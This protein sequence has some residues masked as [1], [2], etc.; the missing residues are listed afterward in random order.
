[1]IVD[2]TDIRVMKYAF[3]DLRVWEKAVDLYVECHQIAITS[4]L[5]KNFSLA[6][7]IRRSALSIP[8][9]IAEGREGGSKRV[10]LRHVNIAVGSAAEL[11]T[12]L[13]C[14]HRLNYLSDDEL[15]KLKYTLDG[16][17]VPLY[18][19]RGHLVKTST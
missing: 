2:L 14:A 15:A 13:M 9:N 10:F 3:E 7:Q 12:Q 19:L 18:K 16:V 17:V 1:M 4:Q 6:D 5:D 8:S 11:R